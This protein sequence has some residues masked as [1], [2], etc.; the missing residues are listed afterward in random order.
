MSKHSIPGDDYALVMS[1]VK[2]L[3]QVQT[4]GP[5]GRRIRREGRRNGTH[6]TRTWAIV[7]KCEVLRRSM[8][9]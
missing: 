6:H 9:A 5:R 8:K 1:M 3:R 2:C 7:K 4:S